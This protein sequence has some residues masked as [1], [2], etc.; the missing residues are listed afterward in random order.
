MVGVLTFDNKFT[1]STYDQMILW[2]L[3]FD[4][5]VWIVKYKHL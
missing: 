1:Y 5:K 2:M 4:T 3:N